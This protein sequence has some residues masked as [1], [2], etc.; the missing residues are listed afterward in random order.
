MIHARIITQTVSWESKAVSETLTLLCSRNEMDENCRSLTCK[1]GIRDWLSCSEEDV[2]QYFFC[3]VILIVMK[4]E[5]HWVACRM[6]SSGYAKGHMSTDTAFCMAVRKIQMHENICKHLKGI[7]FILHS[8]YRRSRTDK[9]SGLILIITLFVFGTSSFSPRRS[10]SI[11]SH[12]LQVSPFIS[13]PQHLYPCLH[14][15]LFLSSPWKYWH[16]SSTYCL[17]NIYIPIS[18]LKYITPSLL[19][20]PKKYLKYTN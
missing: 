20:T 5:L 16:T 7:K 4:V 18:L 13:L 3:L 19:C 14:T 17:K 1:S 2:A 12:L 6:K 10:S 11:H 9:F 15:L 8:S